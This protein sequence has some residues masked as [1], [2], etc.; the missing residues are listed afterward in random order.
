MLR[1]LIAE[2][3]EI[4]AAAL[5]DAFCGQFEI[6]IC[7]DGETALEQLRSFQ[8]D[9]LILNLSLPFKDGL[10]VLQEAAQLPPVILVLSLYS[11]PYVEQA[12]I[13]LGAG[14]VLRMPAV[15][16]VRLRLMDMLQQA[17][18]VPTDQ[19]K[20]AEHLYALQFMPH[21]EGFSL[22]CT[23]I[24]L[25]AQDTRQ[26]LSKE[27]YPAIARTC[28][29]TDGRAVEKT[30]RNAIEAAWK[31]RDE[32]AWLKYFPPDR[33]GKVSCPSNKVFIARLAKMLQ[34]Q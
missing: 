21:L 22:L 28:G 9:A 18:A 11:N 4:Y 27:L 32:A 26:R 16:T 10:T 2:N 14:Y 24:P 12:A 6:R 29:R 20:T 1:L 13:S 5:V 19:T 33:N 34:N 17:P 25:Y 15:N 23:G 7:T 3:S 8:P 30:I 31:F